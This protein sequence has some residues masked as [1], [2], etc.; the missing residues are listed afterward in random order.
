MKKNK[1][2]IL[3]LF[4]L[5]VLIL[6][7][8]LKDDLDDIVINLLNTNLL[9]I[10]LILLILVIS[11]LIKAYIFYKAAKINRIN[12]SYLDSIKLIVISHFFDGITPFA[13]GGQAYQILKLKNRNINY[14][15][16]IGLIFFNFCLFQFSFV[17]LSGIA[18]VL[19][20]IFKFFVLTPLFNKVLLIGYLINIVIA[21]IVGI[22]FFKKKAGIKS[23]TNILKFFNKIK[24]LKENLYNKLINNFNSVSNA[25]SNIKKDRRNVV[26]MLIL[27]MLFLITF[28]S[29][30]FLVFMSLG[31]SDINMFISLLVYMHV[32]LIS[33]YVPMPGGTIGFEYTFLTLFGLFISGSILKAGMLLWRFLTYYLLMIVGFVT[34]IISKKE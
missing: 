15:N 27:N 9:Y 31:I 28:Y 24:I 13:S 4:V 29:V 33:S 1:Y 12:Y 18:I 20:I 14:S 10:L 6:F 3:I 11:D 8:T 7:F 5:T 19:N 17:I 34:F 2:N 21:F 23:I 32:A 25:V 26:K 16:G 22:I 30:P